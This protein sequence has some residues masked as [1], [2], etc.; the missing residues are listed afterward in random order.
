MN[1]DD[2]LTAE[3]LIAYSSEEELAGLL[4]EY[5]EIRNSRRMA[6]SIGRF[7]KERSIITSDDMRECLEREYGTPIKFKM[8]SKVFQALRIAVNDELE[9]LGTC[10]KKAVDYLNKSGRLVVIAYHSLEDRIVKNFIKD[11]EKQCVCE[12]EEPV[13]KCNIAPKLKRI[14]K[15]VYRASDVEVSNNRRARSARLRIAEKIV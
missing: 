10:L 4:R 2:D 13:C 12:P 15:R 14:N 1:P 11:N 5:G 8:L 7:C 6:R 3:K 9:E